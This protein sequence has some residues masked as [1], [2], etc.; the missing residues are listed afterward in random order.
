[1]LVALCK[2]LE[3]RGPIA[4]LQ[5][6]AAGSCRTPIDPRRASIGSSDPAA[7]RPY[8]SILTRTSNTKSGPVS[9]V[10]RG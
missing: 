7:T 5:R 2:A 4:S 10:R 6:R 1:M 8:T 9:I 3:A